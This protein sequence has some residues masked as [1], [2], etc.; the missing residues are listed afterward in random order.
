MGM[1]LITAVAASTLIM[2]V[3]TGFS[4]PLPGEMQQ[5]H[6]PQQMHGFCRC[7]PPDEAT[8]EKVEQVMDQEMERM[9]PVIRKLQEA[10]KNL[11][12]AALQK[13]FNEQKV[14]AAASEL[15]KI[16]TEL[17]VSRLRAQARVAEITAANGDK[18]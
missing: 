5:P 16:E 3:S 10:R 1:K 2:G 12:K 11:R 7:A 17:T 15:G 9:E 4:Q 13:P 8:R 14:R 18:K 6:P